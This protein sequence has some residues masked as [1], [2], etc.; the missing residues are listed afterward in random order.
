VVG[1]EAQWPVPPPPR[2]FHEEIQ[3]RKSLAIAGLCVFGG[4]YLLNAI[5]GGFVAGEPWLAAPVIGPFGYAASTYSYSNGAN[6]R[7]AMLFFALDGLAQAAGI[8]MGIVG[9]ATTTTVKVYDDKPTFSVVPTFSR[10]QAGMMAV[11]HF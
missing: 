5:L 1:P 8:V 6:D 9:L 3:Q 11:A 4:V 7:M 2:P 10:D